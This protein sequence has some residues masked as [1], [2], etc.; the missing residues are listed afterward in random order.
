MTSDPEGQ[1]P[2]SRP[3]RLRLVR[4]IA[5]VV[6]ALVLFMALFWENGGR[7]GKGHGRRGSAAAS[8]RGRSPVGGQSDGESNSRVTGSGSPVGGG[9]SRSGS[10][11]KGETWW[12]SDKKT[13]RGGDRSEGWWSPKKGD[14]KG[15]IGDE[16]PVGGSRRDRSADEEGSDAA[17]KRESE[18][19]NRDKPAHASPMNPGE[20]VGQTGPDDFWWR[21]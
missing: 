21:K 14:R 17:S 8:D 12:Y 7:G 3:A 11:A 15:E 1:A 5:I 9:P 13:E 10:R 6:A 16:S 19:R 18:P 20:A 2:G 4:P